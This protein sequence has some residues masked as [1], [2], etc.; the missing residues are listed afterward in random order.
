MNATPVADPAFQLNVLVQGFPGKSVC[1][2]GL[3]WSTIALI[4]D[5]ERFLKEGKFDSATTRFEA[6]Q[7]VAP[8]NTMVTIGRG[9]AA[10]GAGSYG[11]TWN[12]RNSE[13]RAVPAGFYIIR[14]TVDGQSE[15]RK[16]LLMK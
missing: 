9:N 15:T 11:V 13:G 10:L 3:G 16:I 14:L 2:G 5:G 12:G 4:R 1:H 7:Q 6:A 8:N